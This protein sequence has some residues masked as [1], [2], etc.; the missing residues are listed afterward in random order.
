[1]LEL[2]KYVIGM[3]AEKPDEIVYDIVDDGKNVSV[4]VTLSSSDMG[5]L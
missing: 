3:F 1:M 2:I 4:T 5:R